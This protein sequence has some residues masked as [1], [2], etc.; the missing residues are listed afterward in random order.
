MKY[1]MLNFFFTN[2]NKKIF[3]SLIKLVFN[4]LLKNCSVMLAELCA[5]FNQ[6]LL[7]KLIHKI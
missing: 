6:Y 4:V 3:N 7:N 5:K 1:N 2:N